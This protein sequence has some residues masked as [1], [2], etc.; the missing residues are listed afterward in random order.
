[1][2]SK[3]ITAIDMILMV[4]IIVIPMSVI[5]NS[6]DYIPDEQRV[7][8]DF[9]GNYAEIQAAVSTKTAEV[10]G[11]AMLSPD[12]VTKPRIMQVTQWIVTTPSNTPL[13]TTFPKLSGKDF[14]QIEKENYLDLSFELENVWVVDLEGVLYHTEGVYNPHAGVLYKTPAIPLE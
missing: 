9:C 7:W 3:G 5:A 10:Y 12:V 11:E 1:M 13:P 14:T 4:M 2:I 8:A 6:I